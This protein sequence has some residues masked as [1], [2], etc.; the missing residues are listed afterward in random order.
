MRRPV[1]E[2]YSSLRLRRC[3]WWFFGSAAHHRMNGRSYC[4]ELVSNFQSWTN[5]NTVLQSNIDTE[6]VIITR[7]EPNI[8]CQVIIWVGTR[9]SDIRAVLPRHG[10][11]SHQYGRAEE[12]C[13]HSIT[14]RAKQSY[15]N[16]LW[17]RV[18]R[19][20]DRPF[21]FFAEI[22]YLRHKC[23]LSIRT[24]ILQSL[25][26]SQG[27]WEITKHRQV[28][29]VTLT[30]FSLSCQLT[31]SQ[32]LKLRFLSWKAEMFPNCSL[33]EMVMELSTYIF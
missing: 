7:W 4:D 3:C 29:R 14:V 12:V 16:E 6:W 15:C 10:E 30:C 2:N 22:Y 21:H 19:K 31:M 27:S 33:W 11:T 20:S 32:E 9:Y 28:V 24:R 26:R 25:L 17:P 1:L 8:F 5:V 23:I 13:F 18:K